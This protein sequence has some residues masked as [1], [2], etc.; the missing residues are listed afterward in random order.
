MNQTKTYNLFVKSTTE[1]HKNTNSQMQS[2]KKTFKTPLAD[3]I[4]AFSNINASSPINPSPF[5]QHALRQI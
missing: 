5:L 1:L 2:C 4:A 3:G